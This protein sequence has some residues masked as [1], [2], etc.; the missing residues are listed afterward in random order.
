MLVIS[1]GTNTDRYSSEAEPYATHACTLE[2]D[3]SPYIMEATN[4]YLPAALAERLKVY[5]SG[6]SI[7]KCF[8]WCDATA[9]QWY[10]WEKKLSSATLV[11]GGLNLYPAYTIYVPE[12]DGAR[13]WYEISCVPVLVTVEET[14]DLFCLSLPAGAVLNC[15]STDGTEIQWIVNGTKTSTASAG[16]GTLTNLTL[17]V[18]K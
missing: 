6:A 7:T 17:S 10:D 12:D 18:T 3:A 2:E 5:H 11:D 4:D 15:E 1:D 14:G 13:E 8:F 16:H 9:T